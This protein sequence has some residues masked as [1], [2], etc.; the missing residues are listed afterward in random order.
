MKDGGRV[1][2]VYDIVIWVKEGKRGGVHIY[3]G[4]TKGFPGLNFLF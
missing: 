2:G 1:G 4:E 3:E